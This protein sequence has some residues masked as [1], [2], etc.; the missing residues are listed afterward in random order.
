VAA[1]AAPRAACLAPR[2][3]RRRG[4]LAPG[5]R[6]HAE[7][8]PDPFTIYTM[9]EEMLGVIEQKCSLLTSAR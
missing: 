9:S 7:P 6:L 3:A 2:A 4:D 8:E 5:R 1:D